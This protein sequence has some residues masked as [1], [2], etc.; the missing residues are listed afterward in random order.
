MG[1]R[2]HFPVGQIE[3][4]GGNSFLQFCDRPEHIPC[5][6][7]A[8]VCQIDFAVPLP[9]QQAISIKLDIMWVTE[10]FE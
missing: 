3:V 6:K 2:R 9:D 10:A 7:K 1:Q 4:H 8:G 5:Q